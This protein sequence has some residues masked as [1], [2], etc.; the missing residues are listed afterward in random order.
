MSR[1]LVQD[2]ILLG[3]NSATY[4]GIGNGFFTG[5]AL[6]D[7]TIDHNTVTWARGGLSVNM[8]NYDHPTIRFT[9]SNNLFATIGG[10]GVQG[11]ATGYPGATITH[12]MPDGRVAGN[13]FG[14]GA[15][16]T[17][18][19]YG[20]YPAGNTLV[21]NEDAS[22]APLGFVNASAGDLTLLATSPA[23]GAASDGTDA[24]ANVAA[25][26]AA[27]ARALRGTP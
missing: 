1:V 11:Q 16:F 18:S 13:V 9:L 19:W 15:Q 2:N 25:V 7:V 3:I 24:G 5:G 22:F 27:A 4:N 17:T 20:T 26:M 14:L 6:T 8:D 10:N 21:V 23:K 12:F